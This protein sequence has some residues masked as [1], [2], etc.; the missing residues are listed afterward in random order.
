M[1]KNLQN[2]DELE[3]SHKKNGSSLNKVEKHIKKEIIEKAKPINPKYIFE[4][5][6]T[7]NIIDKRYRKPTPSEDQKAK[8][9]FIGDY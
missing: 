1:F 2:I 8:I 9:T 4:K 5:I 6:K 7:K 3:M